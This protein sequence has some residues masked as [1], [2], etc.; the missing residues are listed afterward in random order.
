MVATIPLPPRATRQVP[1]VEDSAGIC[2]YY[3]GLTRNVVRLWVRESTP[4]YLGFMWTILEITLDFECLLQRWHTL[5]TTGEL[6]PGNDYYTVIHRRISEPLGLTHWVTPG[7]TGRSFFWF[8]F[9]D[10]SPSDPTRLPTLDEAVAADHDQKWLKRVRLF[11]ADTHDIAPSTDWDRED[12]FM[13][14]GNHRAAQDYNKKELPTLSVVTDAFNDG[15]GR[16]EGVIRLDEREGIFVFTMRNGDIWAL[17][18]GR[19]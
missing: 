13:A 19:D 3:R 6:F 11:A 10:V 12:Q 14:F 16:L 17:R 18:Y 7:L 5:G 2:H 8:R 9:A 1:L 4:S 15:G